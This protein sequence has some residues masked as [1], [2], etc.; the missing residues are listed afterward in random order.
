MMIKKFL[1]GSLKSA[2]LKQN[3]PIPDFPEAFPKQTINAIENIQRKFPSLILC[4][5]AAL[6]LTSTLP[7]RPMHDIDFVLNECNFKNDGIWNKT[8]PYASEENDGYTS[9]YMLYQPMSQIGIEINLL[10]FSNDV[11][12]KSEYINSFGQK[13]IKIQRLEDI[14]YWKEKYNRPKDIQD[15]DAIALKALEDAVFKEI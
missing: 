14:L 5:S 15:L 11:D 6:M 10:V 8:K 4:G 1:T 7:Y 3:D 12:L 13:Q 2:N 9:Y